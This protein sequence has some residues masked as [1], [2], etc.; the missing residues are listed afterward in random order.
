MKS[1]RKS[2]TLVYI[3][4]SILLTATLLTNIAM[5]QT[6]PGTPDD[7]TGVWLYSAGT[8]IPGGAPTDNIIDSAV[9]YDI[10]DYIGDTAAEVYDFGYGPSEPVAGHEDT[11]LSEVIEGLLAIDDFGYIDDGEK[12][13]DLKNFDTGSLGYFEG[14]F[15]PATGQRIY[16][17]NT[18]ATGTL[19]PNGATNE[20]E[21]EAALDGC[22]IFIFEDAEL[23]GMNII[24]SNSLGLNIPI[25]IVDLQVNPPTPDGADDTLIAIDLDTLEDFDGTFID[26][27]RIQDDGITLPSTYGDTTLEIDAIATRKSVSR[28]HNIAVKSVKQIKT[29]VGQGLPVKIEVNITNA[30]SFPETFNV[31]AYVNA[32]EIDTFT[33]ITLTSGNSITKTFTWDTTFVKGNYTLTAYATPV[34]GEIYTADNTLIDGWVFVT[35]PGDVDG[36]RD[37]DIFDIILLAGIYGSTEH[38]PQFM[39]NCDIDGDGD[40]DIFDIVAACSHYGESW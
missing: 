6:V 10:L 32:T 35:I 22:E 1:K 36:D 30:G 29:V 33:G 24:L 34:P 7:T 25:V 31:T 39:A 14:G 11:T 4:V 18:A 37:V 15:D 8:D 2:S 28:A 3:L 23:S 38:D 19:G 16:P 17:D 13:E 20:T 5:A 40:V 27:I 26:T 9:Y 21:A 12:S